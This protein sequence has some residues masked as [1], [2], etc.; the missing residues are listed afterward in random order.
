MTKTKFQVGTIGCPVNKQRLYPH[1]DTVEIME[2]YLTIPKEATAA[3]WRE[4]APSHVSFSVQLPR[5]LFEMPTG[6]TPLPGNASEYGGFRISDENI[7]LFEKTLRAA[8]RLGSR[9]LVLLSP[10]SFTP[11]KTN[12]DAL[13]R[14]LE[15]LPPRKAEIV[16]QPSGPWDQE[17]A[18]DYAAELGMLLAVD[19][20]RDEP[21][22]G[23]AGYFRL[24]PFA[25]MGSRVGVYDLERI[26]ET[27]LA[28]SEVTVVFGTPRGLDD[29][30]NL[31]QIIAESE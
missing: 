4:E 26:V 22:P 21:V 13:K 8:E 25:A 5:Y 27:A 30:K 7:R 28:F 11:A 20:L 12:R 18:A 6:Q 3:R 1:V 23:S 10:V 29:A 24:G 17:Q 16:W 14:F 2:T 9:H 15:A 19:P 31:K